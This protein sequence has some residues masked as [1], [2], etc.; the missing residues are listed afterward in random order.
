MLIDRR[1]AGH[2]IWSY[3][4][5]VSPREE[6]ISEFSPVGPPRVTVYSKADEPTLGIAAEGVVSFRDLFHF[7]N[8][9]LRILIVRSRRNSSVDIGVEHFGFISFVRSRAFISAF[10]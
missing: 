3:Y 2:L 8:V 5:F 1:A 4:P 10:C 9:D 7:G 6:V